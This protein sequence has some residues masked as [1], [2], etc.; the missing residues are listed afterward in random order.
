MPLTHKGY[1]SASYTNVRIWQQKEEAEQVQQM[2]SSKVIWPSNGPLASL[3]V[4]LMVKKKD[5]SLYFCVDF[6]QLNATTV[7]D[8]HPLPHIND[9]LDTLH[10]VRWYSTL[11]LK[12]KY[13]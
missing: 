1:L 2:F 4:G 5:G 7:K 9:L 8:P 3:V 12:S 10:G 6:H 13:R 11:H